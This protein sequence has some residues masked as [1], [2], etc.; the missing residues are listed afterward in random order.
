[1]RRTLLA[2]P[3]LLASAASAEEL[4]VF[5]AASLTD[6]LQEI[7]GSYRNETGT[8][9]GFSFGASSDLARQIVAGAP[10]DV[11]FS[12]DTAQ[13]DAVEKAGLVAPGDRVD[14]LSNVLVV[15]EGA[16]A[17]STLAAPA[18]LAGV[19]RLA[20]ADPEAVPAGVYARKWL[21][22]IGLWELLQQRVVP[23]LDVRA[24]L[25]AVASGNADAAIVYRTDAALSKRV[26]I[27]F[28]VPKA[29]GPSILYVVAAIS[30]S[31]NPAA[32]AFV[33]RL[34]SAEAARVF[35]KHGFIVLGPK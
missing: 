21:E 9:V 33:K 31:R 29:E 2:L 15:I 16:G 26:R 35:E 23:L 20:L 24:A 4:T 12:A 28:E 27:A 19:R 10:A 7:G 8:A 34:R 22:S 18:D 32:R 6:A 30:S 14:L 25:A 17:I 11:F 1:M 5:A 3:L 13:M